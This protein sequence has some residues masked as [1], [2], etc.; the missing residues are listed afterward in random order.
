MILYL[1]MHFLKSVP[2]LNHSFKLVI[3][4]SALAFTLVH[5][6]IL[7]YPSRLAYL[8]HPRAFS[9]FFFIFLAPPLLRINR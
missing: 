4:S 1:F 5:Q 7:K 8:Y 2:P 6:I 9:Q 3:P